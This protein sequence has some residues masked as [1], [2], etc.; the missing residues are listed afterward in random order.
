MV[1]VPDDLGHLE[2]LC[3]Y[4]DVCPALEFFCTALVDHPG[5][6]S[7]YAPTQ[8]QLCRPGQHAPVHNSI[9]DHPVSKHL[10]QRCRVGCS[11]APLLVCTVLFNHSDFLLPGSSF[12]AAQEGAGGTGRPNL[13][14]PASL[15]PFGHLGSCHCHRSECLVSRQ[16]T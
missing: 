16:P 7:S 3:I 13:R 4:S 9:L 1:A 10:V 15:R 6:Y 14:V 5:G 8:R 11:Q 12:Q 2:H